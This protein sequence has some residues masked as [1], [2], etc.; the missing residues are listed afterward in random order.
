MP[1][2]D[3]CWSHDGPDAWC[4]F[5]LSIFFFVFWTLLPSSDDEALK[6]ESSGNKNKREVGGRKGYR[7]PTLES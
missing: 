3:G 7:V 6:A 2:L 4:K 5:F 1:R